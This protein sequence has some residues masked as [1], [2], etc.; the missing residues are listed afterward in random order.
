MGSDGPRTRWLRQTRQIWGNIGAGG[1]EGRE[2]PRCESGVQLG[3]VQV[4]TEIPAEIG[5]SF[6]DLGVFC[7]SFV[8]GTQARSPGDG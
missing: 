7:F 3:H 4:K 2:E 8:E 6:L 5:T 1:S